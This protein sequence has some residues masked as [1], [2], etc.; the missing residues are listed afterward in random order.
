MRFYERL[1]IIIFIVLPFRIE[2][3][4]YRKEFFFFLR[5]QNTLEVE[6]YLKMDLIF[7]FFKE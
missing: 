5:E 4:E 6:K 7:L 2:E 3:R 1:I